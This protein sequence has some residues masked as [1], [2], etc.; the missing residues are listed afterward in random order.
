VYIYFIV[1][2]RIIYH[3]EIEAEI[4]RRLQ[5]GQDRKGKQ[6]SERPK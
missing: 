2:E 3:Q 6:R 4:E 1:N 5:E